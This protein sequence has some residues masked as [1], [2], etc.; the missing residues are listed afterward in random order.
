MTSIVGS[1]SHYPLKRPIFSSDVAVQTE[2]LPSSHPNREL[3]HTYGPHD[4]LDDHET[5]LSAA[6]LAS[7]L[8]WSKEI[9]G[10]INLSS[11]TAFISRI[12]RVSKADP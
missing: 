7:I 1:Q 11:G 9:S 8:K 5:T 12:L 4:G 10:D 3:Q 6:D 2:S